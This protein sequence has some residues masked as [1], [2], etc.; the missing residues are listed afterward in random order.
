MLFQRSQSHLHSPFGFSI[1][2]N[3][4]REGP[5][6][7]AS[8]R[9]AYQSLKKLNQIEV[10]A[11]III[12]LD[13]SDKITM[14]VARNT[15]KDIPLTIGVTA[16]DY[17]DLSNAR[18]YGVFLAKYNWIAFLDADDL[19][20]YNWLTEVYKLICAMIKPEICIFHPRHTFYFGIEEAALNVPDQSDLSNPLPLLVADNFWNSLCVAHRSVFKVC[21]YKP[22]MLKSGLGFEDW[23]WNRHTIAN[24]YIHRVVENVCHYKRQ[25]ADSLCRKTVSEDCLATP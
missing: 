8:I 24:G 17:S 9:S 15:I 23:C 1:I 5:Y 22:N 11:E 10:P 4:H 19:W 25:R 14:Q 12:I 2:I 7:A 16:T 13:N 6:I 21:P 3:G 20:S 18:M